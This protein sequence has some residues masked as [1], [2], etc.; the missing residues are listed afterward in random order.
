MMQRMKEAQEDRR[1]SGAIGNSNSDDYI[2][3]LSKSKK[4]DSVFMIKDSFNGISS[5][6]DLVASLNWRY[7]AK[8]FNPDKTIPLDK[9][10]ALEESL[11]LSASSYGLQVIQTNI[12]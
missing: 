7:A 11:R 8:A 6:D 4:E 5:A 10:N 12:Y 9:W 2:N 3:N 1:K